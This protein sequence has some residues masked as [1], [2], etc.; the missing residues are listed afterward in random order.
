V[1][2]KE[3]NGQNIA[4]VQLGSTLPST[5]PPTRIA[6]NTRCST[7]SRR[8]LVAGFPTGLPSTR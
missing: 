4:I 5:T 6:R 3:T 1:L 8:R 2:A 7:A